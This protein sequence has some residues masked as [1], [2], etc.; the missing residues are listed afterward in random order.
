MT[1]IV[2]L[3]LFFSAFSHGGGSWKSAQAEADEI[4][5]EYKKRHPSI[6]SEKITFKTVTLPNGEKLDL[7]FQLERPAIDKEEPSSIP[8]V[9]YVHG[10][11]WN[12]GS[13]S[14]FTHQSFAL[15]EHG[16]AGVRLE[17]RWKK[18]GAKYPEAISDVMDAIDYIRQHA[19]ELNIDFTK[20]GLAGGSA[21]GHLSAIAAQQTPECICYDGYNGLFDAFDRDKSRFGKGNYTG[22]TPEEKKAASAIYNIKT[23]PP[24]TF[25]YHGSKDVTIDVKQSH[26]FKQAIIEK[27]GT[28]EV[29]EY[30]GVGHSFFNEDPYLTVTT[31]ALL[32]H[33]QFVFEMTDKEPVLSD[34]EVEPSKKKVK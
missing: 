29:L 20:V 21:G 6:R 31:K 18:H 27:G 9:F 15:A 25:L 5:E 22:V 33:T 1:K 13:K 7:D 32:A 2:T 3:L 24:H 28:A 19:D 8:V 23:P 4:T 12:R 11:A 16:I 26:R 14:A 10:G 34:Y 30:L 17:Y